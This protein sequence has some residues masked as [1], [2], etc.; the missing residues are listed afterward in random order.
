MYSKTNSSEST[1]K[2]KAD[3]ASQRPLSPSHSIFVGGLSSRCQ[4][5][6]LFEYFKQFGN[7]LKCEPQ[8]WKRS[9][10]RCRGFALIQC[11]DSATYKAILAQPRHHFQGRN[12]ECKKYFKSKEKLNQY[13]KELIQRKLFVG[14]L[15]PKATTQDLEELFKEIGE[16]DIAYII[17]H[18]KTGRSKGFGYVCF[19]AKEAR[20][21]A[22]RIKD[23]EMFGKMVSC[24]E[25][26]HKFLFKDQQGQPEESRRRQTFKEQKSGRKDGFYV[27]RK[28]FKSQMAENGVEE[29]VGE[30][31]MAQ[32]LGKSVSDCSTSVSDRKMREN[33]ENGEEKGN[34]GYLFEGKS[35]ESEEERGVEEV[36]REFSVGFR[37]FGGLRTNGLCK[38]FGIQC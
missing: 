28:R 8:M 21:R 9:N 22:L 19:K 11:G 34:C 4:R 15:P 16:I 26:S 17:T 3:S 30:R 2:N 31:R 12:I 36:V 35:E 29:R 13:N 7:I 38:K 1:R 23:F 25:Y 32:G 27:R 5:Q 20:D 6:H 33:K 14:G 18:H 24:S 37:L 10:M